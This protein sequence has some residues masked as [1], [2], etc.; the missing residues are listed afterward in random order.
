MCSAQAEEDDQGGCS[1]P[2]AG[3]GIM[4][5]ARM[6]DKIVDQG[7]VGTRIAWVKLAGPIC[8]YVTSSLL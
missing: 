2:T 5:S 7:H 6:A 4:L 3:V 8:N 1:D